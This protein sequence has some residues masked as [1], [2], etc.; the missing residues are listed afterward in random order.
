MDGMLYSLFSHNITLSGLTP[1][2]DLEL[3]LYSQGDS[4]SDGRRLGITAN[5]ISAITSPAVSSASTFTLNQNYLK[6]N[7]QSDSSG[8]LS[9]NYSASHDEANVN[10]FQLAA[11]PEPKEMSMAVAMALGVL[12]ILRRNIRPSNPKNS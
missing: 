2:T 9:I 11:V 8:I 12:A 6:M 4:A 10:G 1:N 5:G 7:V 3:Y